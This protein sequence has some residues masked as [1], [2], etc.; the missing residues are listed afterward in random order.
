M[1]KW[2][3]PQAFWGAQSVG[4]ALAAIGLLFQRFEL[5]LLGMPLLLAVFVARSSQPTER[6]TGE[7]RKTDKY[8]LLIPNQP[9][10]DA[11]QVRFFSPGHQPS[12]L[13][14]RRH[15][16]GLS[17]KSNRTGPQHTF[18][19]Q[20]RGYGPFSFATEEPW[21]TTAPDTVG[22]PTS[23][24]LGQLPAPTRL[25]GLSGARNSRRIGE[26]GELRDI[27]TMR[28]GDSLRRVDWRATGR[29][30]PELNELYVRRTFSYAEGIAELVIDSRDDVGPD[31]DTWRGSGHLR[32]DD[33]TS[34][35][36]AR[37]AAASVAAALISAGDRVGL[38]DL[39]FQRRPVTAAT[40]QRQLFRIQ[41]ALAL[42]APHGAPAAV[43][44]P[45]R[46]PGDAFIYLFSTLL[47]DTPVALTA[48][49]IDQGNPV[50]VVDTLPQV[51]TGRSATMA[52]AWRIT[53]LEREQRIAKLKQ[54][55]VPVIPW[56]QAN[57]ATASAELT[58]IARAQARNRGRR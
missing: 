26:G 13:V 56:H 20:G 43:L 10:V 14:T 3:I 1:K 15:H 36:L 57:A 48:G 21:V 30:S 55:A 25:R 32:M 16:I 38:E 35:D 6:T 7:F 11:V 4:F 28:P 12:T 24:P 27:A 41:Q 17:Y 5:V 45:P 46:L 40:G 39:A 2:A 49:W 42:S 33:L 44:R 51:R 53:N 8:S 58:R 23:L 54:M 18:T 29:R 52:L 34:L 31:L 19:A 50:I 9:N 37:H 47:D 22:L